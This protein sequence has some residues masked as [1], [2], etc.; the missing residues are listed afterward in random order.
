[1]PIIINYLD[2]I[3]TCDI[4]TWRHVFRLQWG[5]TLC[6]RL[7]YGYDILHMRAIP[8]EFVF[9]ARSAVHRSES[10]EAYI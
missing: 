9:E 2:L 8:G 1:M 6:S 7:H 4:G 3:P 10:D 5:L